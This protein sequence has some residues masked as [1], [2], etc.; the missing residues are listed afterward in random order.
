MT[1]GLNFP[2]AALMH[3]LVWT[4][5]LLSPVNRRAV[6]PFTHPVS[7]QHLRV[8]GAVSGTGKLR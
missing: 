6:H 8:P 7:P 5:E 3:W 2:G 1:K 4:S